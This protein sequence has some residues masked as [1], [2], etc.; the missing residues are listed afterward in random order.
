MTDEKSL[1]GLF[2]EQGLPIQ[3][4]VCVT[5][6]LD[7]KMMGSLLEHHSILTTLEFGP[8]SMNW[9]AYFVNKGCLF[10]GLVVLQII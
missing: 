4:L 6:G 1:E 3:G 2:S 5:N 10:Q 9:N 7:V 8:P